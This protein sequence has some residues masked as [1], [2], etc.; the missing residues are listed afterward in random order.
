MNLDLIWFNC[1]YLQVYSHRLFIVDVPPLKLSRVRISGVELTID[2]EW[3]ADQ[4]KKRCR[5]LGFVQSKREHLQWDRYYVSD[6]RQYVY[7]PTA[8]VA[9]T[10]WRVALLRLT[11]KD[12]SRVKHPNTHQET[13]N[14]IK[15]AVHYNLSE[16]QAMFKKYY[17][18]MFV[19]EPLER[20]VSAFRDKCDNDP[21]Y[22]W[23]S[24]EIKRRRQSTNSQQTGR[25]MKR[26]G[27]LKQNYKPNFRQ[28]LE[29]T[30]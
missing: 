8:K 7:C 29:F 6:E 5:R 12:I 24:L 13:D 28:C 1:I 14:F 11:G 16:R 17:K 23:L 26:H 19:R 22:R 30:V 20:L 9:S 2:T 10:S 15:R 18:F 3:C 27:L 4:M 21:K 25:T